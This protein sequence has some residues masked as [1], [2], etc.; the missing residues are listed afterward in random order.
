M[1]SSQR[2]GDVVAHELARM[3]IGTF[4][5]VKPTQE[6]LDALANHLTLTAVTWINDRYDLGLP[7][8]LTR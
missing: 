1:S 8:G 5:A 3:A 2:T 7:E 4:G 6:D